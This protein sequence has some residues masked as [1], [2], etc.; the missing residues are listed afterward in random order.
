MGD[1]VTNAFEQVVVCRII[2]A[3]QSGLEGEFVCRAVALEHNAVEAKKGSAV[4]TAV[5]HFVFK[6]R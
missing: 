6:I 2:R 5:V 4:V 1:T 3:G